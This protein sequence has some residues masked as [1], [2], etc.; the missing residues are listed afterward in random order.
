LFPTP[1]I[2]RAGYNWGQRFPIPV[3]PLNVGPDNPDNSLDWSKFIPIAF[4][5]GIFHEAHLPYA[6]HYNFS[7]QRQFGAATMVSLSYVGTQGHRLMTFLEANP[8][9]PDVCLSVSQESQVVPGTPTCGPYGENGVYYPITGGVINSTRSPLGSNFGNSVW[10][11]PMANSNYNSLEVT[12]RHPVGRLEF[13]V[14][15]TLSKSLDNGSGTKD[16]VN[17]LNYG[18]TKALSAFDATHNFVISYTYRLPFDKLGHANRLTSGWRLTGIT[19]FATGLPVYITESDD[20][21]LMG[22][23]GYITG[24]VDEP[25]H[26]PGPLNITDP[27][28]GNPASGTEPYFNASL[29]RG[30]LVGQL[31]NSNRRFFHGPGLNNWDMGLI[32][33]VRLTESKNLQ[34]RAEFFNIFNHAQFNSPSGNILNAYFGFVMSARAPRIGQFGIKFEF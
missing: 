32:K 25:M 10:M 11:T 21:S 29:F 24:G 12:A 6:E 9:H 20:N 15:Y 18:L 5:G 16:G 7:I 13:L 17:P 2:D 31:G 8:G 27:R 3:P 1:F 28:K 26:I 19:R 34:F 4:S 30:E 23:F 14:G 22:C 33:E